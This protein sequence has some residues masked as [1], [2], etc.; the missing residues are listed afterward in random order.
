LDEKG[1]THWK[2]LVEKVDH[3]TNTSDSYE[4]WIFFTE[5][6]RE[7]I[8]QLVA[9]YWQAYQ[10]QKPAQ[11]SLPEIPNI[12]R[13]HAYAPVPM[14][15]PIRAVFAAY[16]NATSGAI[17]WDQS[18]L[19]GYP[20]Y[21]YK[22]PE[23]IIDIEIRSSA[24]E[25][26][27]NMAISSLWED[28]SQ[29]GDLDSDVFLTALAHAVN[30]PKDAEGY[31]WITASQIL[32]YRAVKPMMSRRND[33]RPR[34]RLGHRSEDYDA[35]AACFTRLIQTWVRVT[36]LNNL[37]HKGERTKKKYYP[38]GRLL[39]VDDSIYHHEL[40]A[41]S[42]LEP[43]STP[44][45]VA[46]RYRLGPWYREVIAK[47]QRR[48][49]WI[50]QQALH[51]DPHNQQW[52]KRLSHYFHFLLSVVDGGTVTGTIGTLIDELSLPINQRDPEKTRKRFERA[53][54][55][56]ENDYQVESW[57]LEQNNE[58]LPSRRQ[59]FSTWL[60]WQIHITIAPLLR[61]RRAGKREHL[62]QP[63]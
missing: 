6:A 18:E 20:R 10:K 4:Q 2:R 28:V 13:M 9:L 17:K 39:E 46:W 16:S 60:T 22:H 37:S 12:F 54:Q 7:D 53:M 23:A 57:M 35:I 21:R 63:G 3:F 45:A 43:T 29:L 15:L 30:A 19:N 55:N 34:Q 61:S 58:V 40:R 62:T 25:E 11:R 8:Q 49:A 44:R 36:P 5:E 51:Y 33:N 47:S 56:L 50:S 42:A 14:L 52:E 31:V 48:M 26:E 41:S 27:N 24:G 38:E 59:W 32:D 1:I